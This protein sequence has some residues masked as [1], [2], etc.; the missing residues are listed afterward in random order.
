MSGAKI[1]GNSLGVSCQNAVGPVSGIC[2]GGDGGRA[3]IDFYDM[4]AERMPD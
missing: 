1:T 2:G 4:E 3:I